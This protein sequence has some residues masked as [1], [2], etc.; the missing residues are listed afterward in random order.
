MIHRANSV[1]AIARG[2]ALA[3]AAV[4]FATF[5]MADGAP[6]APS[7]GV[8]P[9]RMIKMAPRMHLPGTV[10]ARNDSKLASQ[11]EGRV[12]WVA[13]VGMAVAA[14]D[15][16]A[17]LDSTILAQ[18]YA[19]DQANVRR[20][21]ASL[22]YDN[23]QAGRM[24]RLVKQNAIATSQR[25]QA[26]SQRDVDSAQ[27]AQAQAELAKTKAQLDYSEIRAPFPGRVVSRLINAGEYASVGKDIV[28]LVDIGSIE[29]KA[30]A[31]IESVRYLR[32]GMAVTVMIQNRPVTTK[33]R[34]IV[35]VGDELS[36]MIEVRL[37][38][39]A[40]AAL[41]GDAATV[42]VPSAQPRDVLAIP[43][44]ALVLRED[45]TYIFKVNPKSVA[46]RIAVQ[47]G[48]EDGR[49]V[50]VKGPIAAGE[51]VVVRGAERLETG[52]KVRAAMAS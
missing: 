20:L 31:P 46:Q 10:I 8:A 49:M 37:T 21:Q 9:A 39:P 6:N 15:V 12:A 41:V 32:E 5:A 42:L 17:K 3:S 22:R 23:Q 13:E 36:R 50:E 24:Q 45:N 14:G 43:R 38:L 19:S 40:G 27:L 51:R 25:D 2:L 30:Q 47:T 28:R 11:V 52:Q 48:A 33:V 4:T 35:P 34:T 16:V 7:V 29:V 44:D 1:R 26:M 18:Q